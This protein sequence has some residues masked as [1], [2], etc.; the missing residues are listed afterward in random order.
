M[1]SVTTDAPHA[2]TAPPK[3]KRPYQDVSM[4]LAATAGKIMDLRD[5]R[6]KT[7][8]RINEEIKDLEKRQRELIGELRSD[9]S[10]QLDMFFGSHETETEA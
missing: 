4:E 6:R 8:K 5:E 1:K 9:N 2:V 10:V 3:A 7:S